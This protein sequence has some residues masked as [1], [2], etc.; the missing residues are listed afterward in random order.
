MEVYSIDQAINTIKQKTGQLCDPIMLASMFMSKKINVCLV[1][2]GYICEVDLI[3]AGD[4]FF[5]DVL[6]CK[7]FDGSIKL[8]PN[9]DIAGLINGKVQNLSRDFVHGPKG[10][11]VFLYGDKQFY[12]DDLPKDLDELKLNP[13]QPSAINI[14]RHELVF[15]AASINSY[16]ASITGASLEA[17][18]AELEKEHEKL[19]AKSEKLEL[20]NEK[21]QKEVIEFESKSFD[22]SAGP[23]LLVAALLEQLKKHA[24]KF[25]QTRFAQEIEKS[26][27]HIKG[28]SSS[29]TTKMFAR[30]NKEKNDLKNK[31]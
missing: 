6:A 20:G 8:A 25:N 29:S 14:T 27:K 5:G 24:P 16:I 28:L 15:A 12:P 21:L 13:I 19:K 23:Y 10:V 11:A 1:Y 22:D 18:Y 9:S 30:A 17:K 4:E 3:P 31:K 7:H 26:N 2:G